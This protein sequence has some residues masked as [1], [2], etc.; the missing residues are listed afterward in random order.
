MQEGLLPSL[1][2]LDIFLE[3]GYVSGLTDVDGIHA[4]SLRFTLC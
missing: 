3:S 4:R 1:D 2:G